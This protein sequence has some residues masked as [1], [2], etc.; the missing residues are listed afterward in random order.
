MASISLIS[1]SGLLA[2]HRYGYINYYFCFLPLTITHLNG[3]RCCG[4]GCCGGDGVGLGLLST[5]IRLPSPLQMTRASWCGSAEGTAVVLCVVITG[6]D[7]LLVPL[8]LVGIS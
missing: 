4:N 7:S 6:N 3:G 2:R 1:F 5:T 8:W